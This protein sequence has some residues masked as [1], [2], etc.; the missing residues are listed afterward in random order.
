MPHSRQHGPGPVVRPYALV[1][2]RTRPGGGALDVISIAYS[3]GAEVPDTADLEPEHHAL[4]A[5]CARPMTVADLSA[6]LHLPLVVIRVLLGDLRDRG[7]IHIE[8]PQP[9]RLNNVRLLR[10][11]AD[12]LRRL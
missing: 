12:G 8:Q 6:A 5:C 4:V 1:R 2:G 3:L 11:V 9:E 7:F 10:E